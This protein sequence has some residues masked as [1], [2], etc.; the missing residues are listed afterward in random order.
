[1][2]ERATNGPQNGL[3]I[4]PAA[5]EVAITIGKELG[6][7]IAIMIMSYLITPVI[8]EFFHW[9]TLGRIGR[10]VTQL[11]SAPVILE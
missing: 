9:H 2:C 1:M 10:N 3:W 7:S 6:K 4:L 8:P 11:Q 5:L